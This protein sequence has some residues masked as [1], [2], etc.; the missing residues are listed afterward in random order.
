MR[1][2]E[3]L[4]S[5][6]LA[7]FINCFWVLEDDYSE[8]VHDISFPDGCA[9]IVFSPTM[10]VLRSDD[11]VTFR[12]Q[13]PGEL[14]GQLTKPYLLRVTGRKGTTFG[15]RFYPHTFALCTSTPVTHYNDITLS[16]DDV[17]Y[18][19]ITDFAFEC[20]GTRKYIQ[21]I[22]KIENFLLSKISK[23]KL[24]ASYQLANSAVKHIIQQ[25]GVVDMDKLIS[26]CNISARYLQA[27][28]SE[29][30]GYSPKFLA[31]IIRFQHALSCI[32]SKTKKSLTS[33]S[34]EAGYFDQSHFIRDFKT[35]TGFLPSEYSYENHPV[36]KFFLQKESCSF[37]YNSFLHT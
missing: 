32:N 25:K 20:I 10:D 3:F 2:Q 13:P 16:A 26:N 1:F 11:G 15:I 7:P 35:F 21:L 28:F 36:N 17:L 8:T 29:N 4:P 19:G 33:I 6:A 9:E 31:R 14:I 34:Y 37:L 27:A 30:V 12:K 24:S 22:E 23:Q 5:K 18:K